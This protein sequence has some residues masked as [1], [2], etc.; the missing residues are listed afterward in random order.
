MYVVTESSVDTLALLSFANIQKIIDL[1]V[2]PYAK[3]TLYQNILPYSSVM[4][5]PTG[6]CICIII[7][8]FMN[9]NRFY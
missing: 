5:S 6:A 8:H 7:R 1:Q 9:K 4:S 2:R 3:S